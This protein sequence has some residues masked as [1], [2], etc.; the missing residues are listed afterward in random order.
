MIENDLLVEKY[1][2]KIFDEFITEKNSG[3][4]EYIKDIVKNN[5]FGLPNLLLHGHAGCGKSSLAR[6][7]AREMDSD[8]LFIDASL[9]TGIATIRKEV[10]EFSQ[11]K[12]TNEEAPKIVFLDESDRLSFAAQDALKNLIE[13][14][15]FHCRFIFSCNNIHKMSEPLL[16][17]VGKNNIYEIKGADKAAIIKRITDIVNNENLTISKIEITELVDA[18]YPD[19]RSMISSL[20]SVKFIGVKTENSSVPKSF[21]DTYRKFKNSENKTYYTNAIKLINDRSLDFRNLLIDIF[22]IMS[23]D[24][25]L[26]NIEIFA[27]ADYQMAVGAT[28]ELAMMNFTKRLFK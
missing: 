1:R 6:L 8:F 18:Y 10:N 5:P 19:I 28:P 3:F 24:D 2:P 22:N 23:E 7:I 25:K 21:V 20:D 11:T 26:N 16:S 13:Q 14:R 9:D 4:I 17:R 12:A 27:E 15:S